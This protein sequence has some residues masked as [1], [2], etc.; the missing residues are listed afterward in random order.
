VAVFVSALYD[1]FAISDT[2]ALQSFGNRLAIVWRSLFDRFSIAS[3][4]L[5]YRFVIAS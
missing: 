3:L 2:I 4:S 5:R 1:P